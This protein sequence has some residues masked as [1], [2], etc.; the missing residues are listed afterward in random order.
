MTGG[1]SSWAYDY[2]TNGFGDHSGKWIR[3]LDDKSFAITCSVAGDTSKIIFPSYALPQEIDSNAELLDRIEKIRSFAA[4]RIGVVDDWRK[5]TRERPYIPFFAICAPPISYIDWTTGKQVNKNSIDLSVRL[6][7][8]QKMHKAYPVSGAICTVAA[9]MI[10]G[11]I[12]N[13]L[14][15]P[16]IIERGALC[17]GHPAGIIIPEGKVAKEKGAF[18][19]KKATVD[20]TARC[21][22]KGYAYIPKSTLI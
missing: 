3:S 17:I 22:M 12:V 14:A 13:Q 4:E 6:L 21:L 2:R 11:T 19:L 5:A 15:R 16:G 20:R 8:M 18:I 10:P 9:S 1:F 7:F